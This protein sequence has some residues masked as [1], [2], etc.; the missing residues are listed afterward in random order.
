MKK[1][2]ESFEIVDHGI[3]QP[4]YFQGCGTAFTDFDDVATGIGINPA[5]A[6]DDALES[7]AQKDWDV[8]GMESRILVDI[9]KRKLPT[10]PRVRARDEDSYYHVS[11]RVK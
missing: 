2:I 9:G 5:E 7:L 4:D 3:T 11:I 10:T 8:D 6:I 1:A